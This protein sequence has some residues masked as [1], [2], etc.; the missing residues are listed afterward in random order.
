MSDDEA[1]DF[2]KGL[3]SSPLKSKPKKDYKKNKKTAKHKK[4]S[5][6]KTKESVQKK[7]KNSKFK[8]AI[9]AKK[10]KKKEKKE[11]KD[12]DKKKGKE[13][14]KNKLALNLDD[15][16]LFEGGK[17][18]ATCQN[19][20]LNSLSE[21]S[22]KETKKK[23]TVAFGLP[24]YIRVK[25]PIFTSSSPKETEAARKGESCSQVMRKSQIKPHDNDFQYNSDDINSQDLFITQKTF[26]A[27]SPETSGSESS[28]G[29]ISASPQQDKNRHSAVGERKQCNE[30]SDKG[31][32]RAIHLCVRETKTDGEEEIDQLHK[33]SSQ[34]GEKA[35]PEHEKHNPFLDDPMI[36]NPTP[37]GAL[38][39]RC[40]SDR[41]DIGEPPPCPTL[42]NTS[43]QTENFF[44]A[45]LSSYV[46]FCQKNR[47]TSESQ[48][49]KPLDLR[50]P[51]RARGEQRKTLE[52]YE[53]HKAKKSLEQNAAVAKKEPSCENTPSPQSEAETKSANTTTSSEDDHHWHAAK[54]D[55]SQ[56]GVVQLRLNKPFFFKTKGEG[57]SPRPYSPLMKLAQ[58][59]D[60]ESKKC[61][62]GRK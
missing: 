14:K 39:K 47:A 30:T 46:S 36:I 62:S 27:R 44:T 9:M 32:D 8:E 49:M 25:R 57:Q 42:A 21:K 45:E 48:N 61:H 59:R 6:T 60:V 5:P 38:I 17:K 1:A 56:V 10:K 50:L 19:E 16:K 37:D 3:W 7:N 22:V 4:R 55:V 29:I 24:S 53:K 52:V 2:F 11:E 51:Q 15:L 20:M 41:L 54:K 40:C 58:G 33:H 23:K 12:R 34:A 43:T 31:Q 13:K 26:R 28:E 35:A 18:L